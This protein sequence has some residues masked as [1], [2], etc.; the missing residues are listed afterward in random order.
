[1]KACAAE[2][3]ERRELALSDRTVAEASTTKFTATGG[4]EKG[5]DEIAGRGD[6]AT[7][8]DQISLIGDGCFQALPLCR[9]RLR[10]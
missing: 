3:Q 8:L 9:T 6:G 2:I 5:K 1:V 10:E 7:M 4:V